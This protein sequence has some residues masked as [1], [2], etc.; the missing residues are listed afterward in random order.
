MCFVV[1]DAKADI[2][3]AAYYHPGYTVHADKG[4][5]TFLGILIGAAAAVAS[6]AKRDP[7]NGPLQPTSGSGMLA[8]K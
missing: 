6:L 5:N 3:M 4:M 2:N 8:L 7:N 1:A